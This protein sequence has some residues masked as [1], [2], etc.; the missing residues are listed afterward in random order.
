MRKVPGQEVKIHVSRFQEAMKGNGI[1]AALILQGADM[2][3]LS[4]T[5]Q[6]AV[7]CVPAEGEPALFVRRC[8]SRAKSDVMFGRVVQFT[9]FSELPS[10]MN[11]DSR[12]WVNHPNY[13]ARY[14]G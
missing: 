2:F 13:T 6:D 7:L 12:E 1:D 5:V 8:F 4:G 11:I 9:R 10:L 14:W 3:Y